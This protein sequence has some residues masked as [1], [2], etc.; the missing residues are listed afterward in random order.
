MPYRHTRCNHD[1]KV[2]ADTKYGAYSLYRYGAWIIKDQRHVGLKVL[3]R[4]SMEPLLEPI[5]CWTFEIYST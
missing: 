2:L 4:K 5:T 1:N 3:N